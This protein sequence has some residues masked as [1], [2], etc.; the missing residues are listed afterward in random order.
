MKLFKLFILF[1]LVFLLLLGCATKRNE[2]RKFGEGDESSVPKLIESLSDIRVRWEAYASLQ[3][4]G[5]KA[6]DALPVLLKRLTST[7]TRNYSSPQNRTPN[8]PMSSYS[9][10]QPKLD[11]VYEYEGQK[12]ICQLWFVFTPNGMSGVAAYA[13]STKRLFA[14]TEQDVSAIIQTIGAIG[15]DAAEAVPTLI[16]FLYDRQTWQGRLIKDGQMNTVVPSYYPLRCV[17]A[18]ALA[19]IG[20]SPELILPHLKNALEDEQ[21]RLDRGYGDMR[22]CEIIK[23][24]IS[25]IE[26]NFN[27]GPSSDTLPLKEAPKN[28]GSISI[29]SDPPGARVF[30]D[31]EFKGLTPAEISLNTG[32]YQIFLRRELYEPYMDSL[33]I[34]KGQTKTLNIQLSPEGEEQK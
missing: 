10:Y 25:K 9:G 6:K 13:Y 30:I 22:S 20:A 17:A 15:P 33:T 27:K 32:T 3:K 26:V 18:N 8:A 12:I 23:Q 1:L 24:A 14:F 31:G 21:T 4:L 2:I 28:Y 19:S 5:P 34:E 29:I 16:P 11:Q 7:E